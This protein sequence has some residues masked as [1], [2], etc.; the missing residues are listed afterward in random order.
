MN[1]RAV[2]KQWLL[3]ALLT[4]SMPA[5]AEDWTISAVHVTQIEASYLPGM[6]AL[7]FDQPVGTCAAPSGWVWY[8]GGSAVAAVVRQRWTMKLA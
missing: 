6:I 1:T 5:S 2:F 8:K 4:I 7:Q 3:L